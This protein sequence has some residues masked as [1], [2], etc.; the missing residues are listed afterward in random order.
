MK[1][2]PLEQRFISLW[3]T[4]LVLFAVVIWLSL[5]LRIEPV[6][7]GII[8]HQAAGSAMEVER[9][10][11]AWAEAG[12]AERAQMAMFGDL[13]FIVIYGLGAW[14][15]GLWFAQ[16]GRPKLKRIGWLVVTA[17]GLFLVTDL[18]ETL[19]QL[20]QLTR[21]RGSNGLAALAAMAQPVKMA[22]WMVTFVGVIAGL[23]VRRISPAAG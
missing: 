3:L 13:V 9:I 7:G 5:P 16:D 10:H 12:L 21:D 19:A 18:T 22:A 2:A 15:G 23:V 20:V 14:Y 1:E 11:Q 8:D 6:P 4:G 17:A